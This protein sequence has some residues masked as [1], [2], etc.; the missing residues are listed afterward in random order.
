MDLFDKKSNRRKQIEGGKLKER[1]IENKDYIHTLTNVF[2]ILRVL[3]KI[4]QKSL[5]VDGPIKIIKSV[6][7]S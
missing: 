7:R 3:I 2:K 1:S 5:R 4:S 6:S